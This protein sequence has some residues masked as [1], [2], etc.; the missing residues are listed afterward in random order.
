M[1][2]FGLD[3]VYIKKLKDELDI[4]NIRRDQSSDFFLL[5]QLDIIYVHCGD[6]LKELVASRL[7][8]SAYGPK[9]PIE[10]EVPKGSR[11]STKSAPIIGPNYFRP[12]T[13]LLPEDRVVYHFIG[14]EAQIV[15][16]ACTDRSKVFSNLPSSL[17]GSGFASSSAQWSALKIAFEKAVNSSKYTLVLRCD[18][19]QYF[20]GINQHEL[21]N[22]LEHQGLAPE[23]VK[24]TERFLSS[25][26]V[27]RSSRGIVQG[28]F[29]SDVLGNGYLLG[30]DEYVADTGYKH[31]R[32]VDDLYILFETQ[33]QFR[34]F[35]PN[36]VKKLRDYDLSLNESK[37]FVTAPAKLLRDET[38]LDKAVNKAK[39]E[40]EEKLTDYIE[41]E[42]EGE[43]GRDSY[44]E[45][46]ETTPETEEVELVATHEI[47]ENIDDFK[48][49]ERD[50]A[51]SF[52]LAFFRRAS[53][54]FAIPYVLKRWVRH[55]E[56]AKEY[57]VYLN[58][59]I[60]DEK[61]RPKIDKA[62]T[63][64]ADQMI[65]FQWAWAGV[66]ARRMKKVSPQLLEVASKIQA[67]GSRHEVVR[68]LLTYLVC[69]HGTALRKKV[70][71]DS[72][73]T[74]PL[75]VQLAILHASGN[76]TAGE[77]NGLLQTAESHG[78]LQGLMC[79]ALKAEN[80]AAKAKV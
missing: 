23:L 61:Q 79:E 69:R 67:D 8:N 53:D 48:G 77:R 46:V 21:V 41:I 10:M 76:F 47:F 54:P 43:Y 70:V 49:E 7:R 40:A 57:A 64:A 34:N 16:E 4:A 11:V 37:S 62:F 9:S 6:N 44:I 22:Q 19:A 24:L 26:T 2:T 63:D 50:R 35:F 60:Q 71:R 73:A 32:Y 15:S 56:K 13:V 65:D 1:A 5:P 45:L 68:S 59:F 3:S 58:K 29:S 28:S 42:V 31:F 74:A 12:G 66:I 17:K 36:F 25:L 72:Y 75:L 51:E 80:K 30:L 55:P 18:I 38:E 33:E 27:D 14:Q 20:W 52:C 39:K 78:A